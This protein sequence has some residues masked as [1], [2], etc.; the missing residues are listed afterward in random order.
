MQPLMFV[1]LNCYWRHSLTNRTQREFINGSFSNIRY[2]QCGVPSVQCP[3]AVDLSRQVSWETNSNFTMDGLPP[4]HTRTTLGQLWDSQSRPDVTQPGFEPGTV[5]T[6]LAL[7]CSAWDRFATREGAPL[8]LR[9]PCVIL[10]GQNVLFDVG[11][12]ITFS[13][14]CNNGWLTLSIIQRFFAMNLVK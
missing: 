8:P 12:Y 9:I 4:G 2:V 7:R 6:P 10:Q 1:I 11:C 5:V 3:W 14:D 13:S